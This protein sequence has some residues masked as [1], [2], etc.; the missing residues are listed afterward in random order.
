MVRLAPPTMLTSPTPLLRSS[1]TLTILSAISVSSRSVRSPERAIV[2]TA[3]ESLLNLLTIGGSVSSGRLRMTLETRSRT[4][5]AADSMSRSRRKVAM[6]TV[7]PAREMLRSSSIPSTVLTASSISRATSISISSGEAPGSEARAE[8]L[9]MST[10]G[11]RSTPSPVKAAAPT[12]TIAR[13]IIEAKTGRSMKVWISLFMRRAPAVPPWPGP[14]CGR[15]SGR[16]RAER[17][18]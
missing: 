3:R 17:R 2:M 18:V 5:W 7:E 15:S 11:R 13:M 8:T 6:T 12:T 9:G 1:W 16:G 14:G 10:E 4:S